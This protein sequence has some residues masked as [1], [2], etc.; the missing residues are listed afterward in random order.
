MSQ[1]K[2]LN[3]IIF[4]EDGPDAT[5]SVEED[6][7]PSSNPERGLRVNGKP[8]ASSRSD[9]STQLLVAHLPMIARPGAKDV[10]IFGL[11][12]GISAG[13][14]QSYPVDRITVA[15]N[16]E[17]VIKASQ[18]FAKWN[19]SILNDS[20]I[21]LWREDARTVLKLDPQRY[22][23]IIAQPSNPWTVGIGSVFSREFY[24]ISAS[25]LKPGGIMAQW[26]HVYE[27]HDGIV[28]LV[29]RT[30][31]S[32]FPYI[33]IWDTCAGDIVMLGSMQPW[34]SNPET[35]RQSFDIAGVKSDMA[36]IGIQSPEALWARQLAS[37]QTAFAIAGDGP[38]QSDLFPIL[39]Y[40]APRAFYVGINAKLF[41]TYD[42]RTRQQQLATV[43]KVATLR[44]LSRQETVSVFVPFSTVNKELLDSLIGP[45]E[46]PV[47]CVFTTN[48]TSSTRNRQDKSYEMVDQAVSIYNQGDLKKAGELAN[49]AI[50]ENPTNTQALFLNRIIERKN[51]L[52]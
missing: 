47:P 37:Q 24:Q 3:K 52:R 31:G 2:Q 28:A 14:L 44:A 18:Y 11:G 42:E 5:V 27:M 6:R 10:F 12:S 46:A 1:R 30:F 49:L 8:D 33:E 9:L 41:E 32:V 40:A 34:Q 13:A 26:F 4:Y 20:R 7:K 35:F 43:A 51:Q 21:H 25:R 22:D 16:C 50:Q 36:T 15:E 19:R 17:P 38:I 45:A 48:V 23:V 29:L 39:E